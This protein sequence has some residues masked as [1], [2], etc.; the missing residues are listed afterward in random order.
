MLRNPNADSTERTERGNATRAAGGA[1][2][3]WALGAGA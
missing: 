2:G 1:G 3:K